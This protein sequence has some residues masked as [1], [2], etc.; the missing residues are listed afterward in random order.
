MVKKANRR[1]TVSIER[2]VDPPK[3]VFGFQYLQSVSWPESRDCVFFKDFL[4]RLSMFCR[5]T[6]QELYQTSRHGLGL[7][8]LPVSVVRHNCSMDNDYFLVLRAAGNNLPFLGF[9]RGDVFEIVFIE[10]RFGDIYN[11]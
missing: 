9:R 8:K 4:I 5:M 10:T 2:V 7:E 6:W 3:V 11:H 1:L